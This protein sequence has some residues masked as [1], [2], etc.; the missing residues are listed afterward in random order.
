[1]LRALCLWV[2]ERVYTGYTKYRLYEGPTVGAIDSSILKTCDLAAMAPT[3]A[4]A[5]PGSALLLKGLNYPD[6]PKSFIKEYTLHHMLNPYMT[7]RIL[8]KDSWK[9]RVLEPESMLFS[10]CRF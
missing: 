2:S 9:L 1:M 6:L 8:M 4:A 3:S 7:L 10:E 5:S